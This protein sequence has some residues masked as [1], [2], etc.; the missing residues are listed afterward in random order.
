VKF[1]KNASIT[2][3]DKSFMNQKPKIILNPTQANEQLTTTGRLTNTGKEITS[4]S[5]L[6]K[7]L[8]YQVLELLTDDACQVIEHQSEFYTWTDSNGLDKEMDGLT[9]TAI[10]LRCLH[11]HHK[12]YMSSEIGKVKKMTIAQYDNDVNLYF[13]AIKSP[14]VQIDRKD[15]MA[16]TDDAFVHDIF[17][18]LKNKMLPSYFKQEFTSLERH[19]RMDK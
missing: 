1:L 9:I 17:A 3:G 13:D 16:Y 2:L 7:I 15:A 4:W 8:A 12:V 6:S 14:K 10:I 18:Q 5:I 19:W 11:P